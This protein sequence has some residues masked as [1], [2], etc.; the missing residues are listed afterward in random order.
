[1]KKP[2]TPEQRLASLVGR[3]APF[4]G[5]LSPA[6]SAPSPSVTGNPFVHAPCPR[7]T[8]RVGDKC[9]GFTTHL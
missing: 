7:G 6:P 5:A 3:G 8:F 4:F 1:M 9:L 2:V